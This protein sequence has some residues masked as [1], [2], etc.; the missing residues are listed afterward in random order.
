MA[1]HIQGAEPVVFRW[2]RDGADPDGM[3]ESISPWDLRHEQFDPGP[4]RAGVTP[5]ASPRLQLPSPQW[6][7]ARDRVPPEA[8]PPQG[9][10]GGG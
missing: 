1:R 7:R 9:L 8:W 6:S 2:S 4:F 10:A 3:A 5:M